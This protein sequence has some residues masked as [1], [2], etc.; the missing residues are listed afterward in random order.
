MKTTTILTIALSILIF[1]ANAEEE[2]ELKSVSIMGKENLELQFLLPEERFL[3][4]P[5][6]DGKDKL[7]LALDEAIKIG[8][9]EVT[10]K[11]PRK[12]FSVDEIELRKKDHINDFRWYYII[13]FEGD[14][15]DRDERV[16]V[17]LDGTIVQP[18]ITER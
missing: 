12:E 13:Q 8:Q 4:T 3:A 5:Q 2:I 10:R 14:I 9:S 6:W 18:K 16:Y 17:L 11:N 1:N 15:P 7:P